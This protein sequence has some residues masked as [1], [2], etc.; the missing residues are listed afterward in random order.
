MKSRFPAAGLVR[1]HPGGR[2]TI[3]RYFF[4]SGPAASLSEGNAN[5]LL[6][7]R[8]STADGFSAAGALAGSAE[9]EALPASAGNSA[10]AGVAGALAGSAEGRTA[11]GEGGSGAADSADLLISP[12]AAGGGG[13]PATGSGLLGS[14]VMRAGAG[15]LLGV[16]QPAGPQPVAHVPPWP[17][18]QLPPA[19]GNT[20]A[21]GPFL[22]A[23]T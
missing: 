15:L 17:R 6:A 10:G 4:P 23:G 1:H 2:E 20:S 5:G 13:V 14:S 18:P 16:P 21:V 19:H 9:A 12:G 7:L 22:K 8:A 3:E 11:G